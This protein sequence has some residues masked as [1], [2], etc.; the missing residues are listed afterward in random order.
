MLNTRVLK[1]QL[2]PETIISNE[3]LYNV[4]EKKTLTVFN[5]VVIR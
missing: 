1:L 4:K 2:H 3:L 5:H